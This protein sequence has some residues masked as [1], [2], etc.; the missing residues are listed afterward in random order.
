MIL[1][2]T[3]NIHT[4]SEALPPTIL[5]IFGATGDLSADYLLPAIFHMDM[6]GLLPES[7]RVVAVGRRDLNAKTYLDFIVK[8][9]KNLK[10]TA[11][12]KAHF[13]KHIE[14]FRGEITD[15]KSFEP[16]AKMLSDRDLPVRQAGKPKHICY[17]RLY[18][19]A[20]SP[21]LF[22]PTAQILK[23]SGLLMACAA[24]ERKVRVLVEKPF[25]SDLAS[26]KSL[27]KLLLNYFS[28]DQI[29]RIDH[30]LGKETVQNLMVVRFANFIFEPLWKA[31]FI[32]HIEISMLED[33]SAKSRA[34]FYDHTGALRDVVQNHI[35][36]MLSLITMDEPRELRT[37]DIRDQKLKILKSLVPF[38]DKDSWLVKGQYQGFA[39]DV[40]HASGT[41]TFVAL[42]TYIDTPRWK[43][44]PIYLRT[45]KALQKKITEIS[46]HFKE[47]SRCLFRGCAANII[48][49]RIQPDES[50]HL[51]LNNKVP[52]FGIELHQGDYKFGYD[53]AF[54]SEI[55]V[56][57]ERLLLDFVQG[58]QRLFIRSD[59][60]EAA[61]KFI[62]SVSQG[63]AKTPL[64]IYRRGSRGPK[65][66]DEL[67]EKD[68]REWWTR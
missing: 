48:T 9:S 59:E 58:D 64:S 47:P 7:F 63:L 27:N 13:L 28:E 51:R 45:G 10:P 8:K 17:N 61:W 22:A 4:L 23:A 36:Q 44:V 29:Y 34:E 1:K 14:Y 53:K 67:I 68:L 37:E 65:E 38:S 12:H 39:K 55:P 41:E 25:G 11:K 31:E 30:Y 15:E 21:D 49:F 24:H 43:G 54:M 35:L 46:V 50:V 56:A 62:D 20:T 42:K 3:S 19:F 26:A 18:Y 5:T 16:L 2:H 60:I 32:D 33:D 6:H 57:Y 52:G 40:G 66:T